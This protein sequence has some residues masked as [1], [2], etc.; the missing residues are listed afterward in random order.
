MAMAELRHELRARSTAYIFCVGASNSASR[1][2]DAD[3]VEI[4]QSEDI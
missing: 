2:C 4:M 1:K 3:V